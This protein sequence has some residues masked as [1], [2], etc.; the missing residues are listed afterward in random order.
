VF[1][2]KVPLLEIV[3]RVLLIYVFLLVATRLLGKKEIGRWTPME[4]LGM[5]LLAR[6]VGPAMTG[7]DNSLP[8]A[9]VGAV[10]LLALTYLFDYLAYR[11][12][13]LEALLEGRPEILIQNGQ[14]VEKVMKSE[15]L[16]GQQLD[17]ALRREH[18]ESPEQVALA[19][20]E[21]NGRIS[22]IPKKRPSGEA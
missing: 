17:A 13:T 21:P 19:Y 14:V 9:G 12:R 4:F 7:G 18:L 8:G 2:P 20:I 16:T 1:E 6:L 22:V 3:L 10:T 11:S 5:L 15:L